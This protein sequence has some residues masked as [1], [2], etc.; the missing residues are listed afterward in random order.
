MV[1]QLRWRESERCEA[2]RAREST[3]ER[4]MGGKR[5]QREMG[6]GERSER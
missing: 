2:D 5:R 3:R 1:C 4:V 6:R